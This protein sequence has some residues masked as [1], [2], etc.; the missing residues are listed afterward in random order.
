MTPFHTKPVTQQCKLLYS[1]SHKEAFSENSQRPEKRTIY[2]IQVTPVY[3]INNLLPN[4][5]NKTVFTSIN[6]TF[7]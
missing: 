1:N 7:T 3:F 5:L 2:N 6:V 4:T